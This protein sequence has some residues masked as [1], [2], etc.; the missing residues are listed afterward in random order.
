[1]KTTLEL[2]KFNISI[3]ED[4]KG[5]VKVFVTKD[6]ESIDE[7]VFDADEYTDEETKDVDDDDTTVTTD[8]TTDDTKTDAVDDKAADTKEVIVGESMTFDKYLASK[9]EKK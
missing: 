7:M 1:M 8:D 5:V 4:E 6:G 3:E 9:E 2:S